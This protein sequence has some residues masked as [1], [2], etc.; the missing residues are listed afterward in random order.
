MRDDRELA[1][2]SLLAQLR[3]LP[4]NAQVAILWMTDSK[5]PSSHIICCEKDKGN[6]VFVDPQSGR[7]G[8]DVLRLPKRHFGYSWFRTDGLELVLE[9]EWHEVVKKARK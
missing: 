1:K 5:I 9:F 7:I 3:S 8:D 4:D 6:L 2:K